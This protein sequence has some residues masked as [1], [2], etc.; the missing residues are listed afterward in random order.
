MK[1][2]NKNEVQKTDDG[3]ANAK[4]DKSDKSSMFNKTD[5]VPFMLGIFLIGGLIG[6]P[7]TYGATTGLGYLESLPW[8]LGSCVVFL[9]TFRRNG[10]ISWI[11]FI[12]AMVIIIILAGIYNEKTGKSA[13]AAGGFYGFLL[14]MI[15]GYLGIGVGRILKLKQSR[16]L[17]STVSI[18]GDTI[19]IN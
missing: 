7:L 12:P 6:I 16:C 18:S 2:S 17:K 1:E 14:I 8:A 15:C 19:L 13:F 4:V 9:I 5:Y 3:I 11:R 10:T